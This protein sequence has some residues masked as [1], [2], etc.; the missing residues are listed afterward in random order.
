[1]RISSNANSIIITICHCCNVIRGCPVG[2]R[3]VGAGA[4][5]RAYRLEVNEILDAI[6]GVVVAQVP[7]GADRPGAV[8]GTVN[9]VRNRRFEIRA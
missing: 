2:I 4:V 5:S 8:R 9:F 7:R 1:V 3:P 6:I